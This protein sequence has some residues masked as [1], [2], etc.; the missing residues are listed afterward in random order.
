LAV[1]KAYM[2]NN[3]GVN[4]I[5]GVS[6]VIDSQGRFLIHTD[7]SF[8][9]KKVEE[10][11]LSGRTPITHPTAMMRTDS[12]RLVGGYKEQ[13]FPAEDLALWLEL[14]EIGEINNIEDVL[15]E[16]RIHDASISTMFHEDQLDKIREICTSACRKRGVEVEFKAT[17]GRPG[18]TRKSKFEVVLRHGWWAFGSKQWRTSAIYAVKS[19]TIMPFLDGGWR[20]LLCSFFRRG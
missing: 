9:S 15:L 16:Y 13:N 8:G 11:A 18:V 12:L 20:L 2:D 1:Q 4:C 19:I 14:S 10:M 3:P 5:G 6:R 17:V 7:T